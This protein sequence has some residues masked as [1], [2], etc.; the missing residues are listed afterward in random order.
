M[1]KKTLFV[2]CTKPI[3]A[4]EGINRLFRIAAFDLTY[5]S[6]SATSSQCGGMGYFFKTFARFWHMTGLG[7]NCFRPHR[8][9]QYLTH[10]WYEF[11]LFG[12]LV[13]SCTICALSDTDLFCAELLNFSVC[14]KMS[15]IYKYY[16]TFVI[17]QRISEWQ[18]KK[19]FTLMN[20]LNKTDRL[21]KP[22]LKHWDRRVIRK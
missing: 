3:N 1:K 10:S 17:S 4:V 19:D 15:M 6:G 13:T 12:Q 16:G 2:Q 8:W 18:N 21:M 14:W 7:L 22:I 11:A 5:V 20:N 9:L